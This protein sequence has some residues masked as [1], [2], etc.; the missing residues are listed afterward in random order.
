MKIKFVLLL[1][2]FSVYLFMHS[3]AQQQSS[4]PAPPMLPVTGPFEPNYESLSKQYDCPEWFRDAKFGIWAHW[5]P[6]SVAE[7]GDWFPRRMYIQ[8]NTWA[9]PD[10]APAY[11]YHLNKYGHPSEYGFKDIIP[12]FKAE[13]WDPEA[14]MKLYKKAG[15]RYFMAMGMHHDNFDLWNSK[16]QPWNSVNMGPKRDM[17]KEWQQAAKHNNLKFGVSNHGA[18]TWRYWE[19]TRMAD[20][21]GPKKGVPYDGWLTKA[22]GKGKWWE[23]YDPRDLY[24][25]PHKGGQP[26]YAGPF[27]DNSGDPPDSLFQAS[28]INRMTDLIDNYHPDLIYYDGGLPFGRLDFASYYYNESRKWNK[29]KA[30]VAIN[31]KGARTEQQQKAVVADFEN[32]QSDILRK[33]P[34]QTDTSLDGWFYTNPAH[35]ITPGRGPTPTKD[36]ILQ[37][38]DIVSKNGNLL[39][40]I[41]L[42]SDGTI[43]ESYYKFLDEMAKWMDI[44][45]EAIHG[46]RPWEIFGEGPTNATATTGNRSNR[47]KEYTAEDIRFTTKDKSLYAILMSWPG[48]EVTIKSLPKEKSLWLGDIKAIQML[49]SKAPLK[50]VQNDKGIT[51]QL[52]ANKPSEFACILKISGK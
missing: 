29:G 26:A 5:G 14:L 12:L 27:P 21:A 41:N 11:T 42:R 17:V 43:V 49:G 37:L 28:L 47:P 35:L 24:G 1:L 51:V 25:Q 22:D 44:N 19:I 31:I 45:S 6:N 23:G 2:C 4:R 20:T 16:Y 32:A 3:Y 34:W 40:N 9:F 52:P 7:Y 10:L 13:K 38:V 39:L 30:D 36:V 50:W 48:K 15:A 18:G 33:Y 46:T 8:G